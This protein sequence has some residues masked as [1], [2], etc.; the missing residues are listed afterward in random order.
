MKKIYYPKDKKC[1]F[2]CYNCEYLRER[3]IIF[4]H[5]FPGTNRLLRLIP[6]LGERRT[7]WIEVNYRGDKGTRENFSLLGSIEDIIDTTHFVK[8]RFKPSFIYILGYS[9]GGFCTLN[10][11]KRYPLLYDKVILLNPVLD[12]EFF[13]NHPIM[14]ILW[15]EAKKILSLR[16]EEFYKREIEEIIKNYNPLRFKNQISTKLFLIQSTEDA[17][18][19]ISLAKEF[20]N[21]TNTTLIPLP[22][23]PHDL[24]GDELID[25]LSSLLD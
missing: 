13:K 3:V 23:K 4:A 21:Y 22:Q 17:L 18:C 10:V 19:P 16:E 6:Y 11:I 12:G 14:P 1:F 2:I 25:V 5:G 9:Y 7:A 24:E 8:E 20:A 15:N